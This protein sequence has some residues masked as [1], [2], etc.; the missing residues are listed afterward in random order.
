[1]SKEVRLI[2]DF[3]DGTATINSSL[4]ITEKRLNRVNA[5]PGVDAAISI[6]KYA[7]AIWFAEAFEP[8]RTT[9]RAIMALAGK[10]LDTKRARIECETAFDIN[11]ELVRLRLSNFRKKARKMAAKK[12]QVDEKIEN[13]L[14]EIWVLMEHPQT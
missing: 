13:L 7:L 1:M 14:Q 3:S 4:R 9:A 8:S 5:C 10:K 2:V 12:A 11:C 6:G